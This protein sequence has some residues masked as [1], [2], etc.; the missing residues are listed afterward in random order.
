MRFTNSSTNDRWN[1]GMA[2]AGN[3]QITAVGAADT[4]FDLDDAGNLEIAG[5]LTEGSS[6]GIKEDFA[7]VDVQAILAAVGELPI[8]TWTYKADSPRIRHLGPMAQ[9]FYAAFGLGKDDEHIA[10]LDTNGV[11]LA[12][13]Q[14]LLELS[15]EQAARIAELEARLAALEK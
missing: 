15:Q 7:P 3:F 10:P 12:A 13:I 11:A 14:A 9:D 1:F 6:V 8:T 2:P 4:A 5:S